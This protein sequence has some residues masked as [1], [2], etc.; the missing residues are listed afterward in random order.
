[1]YVIEVVKYT[2]TND[3]VIELRKSVGIFKNKFNAEDHIALYSEKYLN[4]DYNSEC[5][6]EI[7]ELDSDL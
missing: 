2:K 1:M 4:N 7:R 5:N 3:G 6:L